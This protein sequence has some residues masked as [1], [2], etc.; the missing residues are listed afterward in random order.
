MP[1]GAT[2]RNMGKNDLWIAATTYI[3]KGV[4]VTND[5]DFNH[6]AP[7]FFQLRSLTFR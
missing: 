1:V 2:S 7:D 4:L 6:L 3:M 5:P